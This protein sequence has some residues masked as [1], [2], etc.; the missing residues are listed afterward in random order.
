M[1]NSHVP[2]LNSLAIILLFVILPTLLQGFRLA[3]VFCS[4]LFK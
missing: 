1:R 4:L 3:P 2:V